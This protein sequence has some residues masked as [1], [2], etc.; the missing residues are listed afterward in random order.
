MLMN[1]K[2]GHLSTDKP[3][4]IFGPFFCVSGRGMSADLKNE[5]MRIL[6]DVTTVI[7]KGAL[8]R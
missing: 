7:D 1:E 4:K 6:S 3:I 5:R 2:R 8:Y